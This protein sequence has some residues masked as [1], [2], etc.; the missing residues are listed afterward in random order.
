LRAILTRH[1]VLAAALVSAVLW[2]HQDAWAQELPRQLRAEIDGDVRD[3]TLKKTAFVPQFIARKD[4][5]GDG[6]MD[7]ILDY[8][9]YKC[10]T[11]AGR[12]CNGAGCRMEVYVSKGRTG[13]VKVFG[14][15]VRELRFGTANGRPAILLSRQGRAC[16]KTEAGPCRTTL[17]W[18]GTR[19]A[20]AR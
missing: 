10:G 14:G 3:C 16:G 5:N 13:Y 12:Y 8:G 6:V 11:L 1:A 18:D 9:G 4:L 20:E 7:F 2:S 19:F 17:T 15:T